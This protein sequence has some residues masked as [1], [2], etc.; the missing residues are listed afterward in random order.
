LKCLAGTQSNLDRNN[1]CPRYLPPTPA[2]CQRPCSS[3]NSPLS[4]RP[5][6]G[7]IGI[8]LLQDAVCLSRGV[9]STSSIPVAGHEPRKSGEHLHTSRHFDNTSILRRKYASLYRF[10]IL[11]FLL[12]HDNSHSV[13]STGL[14]TYRLILY[15]S[16][17]KARITSSLGQTNT[18]RNL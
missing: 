5:S 2:S 14:Q 17:L 10:L 16:K 8:S 3:A 9:R 15:A 11:A 18:N 4:C 1:F 7:Y 13:S 6:N 12:S